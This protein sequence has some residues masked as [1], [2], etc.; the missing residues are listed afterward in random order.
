[1]Y[2]WNELLLLVQCFRLTESH[3]GGVSPPPPVRLRDIYGK[4]LT[5]PPF[6][7]FLWLVVNNKILTR[8]NLLKRRHADDIIY[9]ICDEWKTTQ[10]LFFD[11]IVAIA[12]WTYISELFQCA[13]PMCMLAISDKWIS[14]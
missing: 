5:P 6:H 14:R 3:F 12:I 8:D 4:F 13:S 9:M 1:M 10:Q 7:V 2:I 11:Y